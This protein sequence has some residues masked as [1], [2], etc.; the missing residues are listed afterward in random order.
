MNACRPAAGAWLAITAKAVI[1]ATGGAAASILR[2]DNPKGML[3]D[4]YR[5]ALQAGAILQDLEF[6]QFYPL[7]LAEPGCHR[8]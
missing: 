4:G 3:G 8:W 1:L 5:L 6:V 7:C 2:H